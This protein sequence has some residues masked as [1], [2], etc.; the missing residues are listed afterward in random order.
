MKMEDEEGEE[1]G[2][3]DGPREADEDGAGAAVVIFG[4]VEECGDVLA[5][6]VEVAFWTHCCVSMK[7]LPNPLWC[8]ETQNVNERR[9]IVFNSYN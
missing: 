9:G 1:G 7:S 2:G 3:G 5:D 4:L 6:G 8:L